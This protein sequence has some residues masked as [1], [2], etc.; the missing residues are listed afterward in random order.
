MNQ[1]HGCCITSQLHIESPAISFPSLDGNDDVNSDWIETESNVGLPVSDYPEEALDSID[2]NLILDGDWMETNNLSDN[3]SAEEVLNSIKENQTCQPVME[4]YPGASKNYG[5]G[6]T[7]MDMFDGDQFSSKRQHNLF[8]P[9]SSKNEWE[10]ASWLANSGLS[11]AAI[12]EC[13]SLDIMC[14]FLLAAMSADTVFQIKLLPL[15]F[16]TA[17]VLHKSIELLLSGPWWKYQPIRTE[18]PMKRDLQL[19]YWDAIKCL[20]HLIHSLSINGQ[21]EFVPKKIYTTTDQ[22]ECIYTEWLTGDRA[23]ELQVC[24]L[25]GAKEIVHPVSRMCYLM[26][27]PFLGSFFHPIKPTSLKL[28]TIRLTLS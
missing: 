26:V 4:L 10:F 7:F 2:E 6:H 23:W 14:F 8:Y 18:S 27:Q 22:I 5:Q 17:K 15:L 13:L 20:Q 28:A 24:I 3:G 12:D 1:P 16:R 9:F 25:Q 21:I 19:F 11:M